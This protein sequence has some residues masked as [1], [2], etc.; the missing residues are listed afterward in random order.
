MD[1]EISAVSAMR[2]RSGNSHGFTLF[3]MV[4]VVTIFVFLAGGIYATVN[5]AV[6]ATAALSEENLHSQRIDAFVSLL[7]RTFHN[8]PATAQITGGVREEAGGSAMNELVLRDAPGAFSWG[9][10]GPAA[11]TAVLSARPRLGGGREISL[12]LLPGSLGEMERR[13]AL[14]QGQWLRLL[15]DLRSV[16]WRF[17]SQELQDWAE[18][19]PEGSPRPPL[20]EL[21]FEVLGEETPRKFVFWIPPVQ[22]VAQG[23]PGGQGAQNNEQNN[24]PNDNQNPNNGPNNNGQGNPGGPGASR[25]GQG[26]NPGAPRIQRAPAQQ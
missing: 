10:G 24:N 8:L 23:Q 3:E 5:S 26:A 11:G 17:F 22:E 21:T 9:L 13:D 14:E 12:I 20:I 4:V 18:E 1:G 15:P 25:G 6:R 2:A 19:W 16:S 7:R